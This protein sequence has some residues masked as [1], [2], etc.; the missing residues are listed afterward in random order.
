VPFFKPLH[1]ATSVLANLANG[2]DDDK[3][4]ILENR[5]I[6]SGLRA[7]LSEHKVEVRRPAVGCVLELVKVD[8]KKARRHLN[9]AG[10]ISTLKHICECTGGVSSSPG[11]RTS[12]H[13][14]HMFVEDDREVIDK[15]RQALNLLE[16]SGVD[17][18]T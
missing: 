11:G 18:G 3:V 8:P 1:Q 5:Q 9:E 17:F 13:Q 6:L 15:A 12:S 4:L 10:I 7:C 16:H 2:N 14:W